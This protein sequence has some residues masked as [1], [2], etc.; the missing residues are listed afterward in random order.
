VQYEHFDH[1]R[2]AEAMESCRPG[3]DDLLDPAL[4]PLADVLALDP[5]LAE[6]FARQQRADAAVAAACR[7]VPVPDRLAERLLERLAGAR[8]E[9][10]RAP[11]AVLACRLPGVLSAVEAPAADKMPAAGSRA[12]RP[13]RR[14]S[15]RWLALAAAALGTA[16][17]LLAAVWVESRHAAA[18]TPS[19]VL[20]QATEFFRGESP[21]AGS[22]LAEVA[23]PAAYPIS[24]DVLRTPQLRWRPIRGLLGCSGVAYDLSAPG[25]S[26]ATLYV[27]CRAVPR[28]PT[29]PPRQ[30]WP[31]TAGCTA[32]W[33]D[34]GLL[35]VLVV[36]GG[37]EVYQSHLRPPSGPLT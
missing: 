7:D 17:A 31:T 29:Q 4:A 35:Y 23:P 3:S 21:A 13:E 16:A 24:R 19:A 11:G 26:R 1:E 20:E 34:G 37:P 14:L 27:I 6:R 2:I 15:R 18:C 36:E 12:D 5:E 28:L 25:G 8:A 10:A 9:G 32:A 30:P 22:R 33:Q